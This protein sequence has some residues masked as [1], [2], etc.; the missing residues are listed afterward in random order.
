MVTNDERRMTKMS[1]DHSSLAR[2]S[3]FVR[4]AT[5]NS[6]R[7]SSARASRTLFSG[8]LNH[9]LAPEGCGSGTMMRPSPLEPP[10]DQLGHGRV[11]AQE[12]PIAS[13]PMGISTRG[14]ISA[15]SC[16]QPRCAERLLGTGW[17]AVAAAGG[18]RPGVAAGD[19][20][21]RLG[22]AERCLS[23]SR[24]APASGIAACP[25]GRRTACASPLPRA[26]P[27]PGPR[28]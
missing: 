10:A 16:L 8:T 11:S 13:P 4:S 5:R 28:S 19:R 15:S 27:A 17:H 23:R 14:L 18:V 22:G 20:D 24:P 26:G 12:P 3:S 9:W 7:I 25:R 6:A 21:H 1:D 2:H